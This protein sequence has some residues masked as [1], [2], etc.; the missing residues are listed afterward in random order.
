[1]TSSKIKRKPSCTTSCYKERLENIEKS[2]SDF[3]EYESQAAI[4]N[5]L[6]Q[7]ALILAELKGEQ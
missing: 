6:L 2:L 1:M 4:E 3:W 7:A 5:V